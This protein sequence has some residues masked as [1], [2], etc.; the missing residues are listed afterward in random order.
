[1][2]PLVSNRPHAR[3]WLS[4]TMV[5]KAV[6]ISASCCSL[7]TDKNR[8]QMTSNV[9]ASIALVSIDKLHHHVEPFI[10]A[11]MPAGT[12]DQCRFALFDNRWAGELLA[13]YQGGAIIYASVNIAAALGKV[14]APGPFARICSERF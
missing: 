7:A 12:Y 6:R 11:C 5:L 14:S 3:S 9:T 1:M 13:G 4:R 2:R 8:F 10:D